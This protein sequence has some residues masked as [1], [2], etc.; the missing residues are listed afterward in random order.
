M[1]RTCEVC[2]WTRLD[3]GALC[4]VFLWEPVKHLLLAGELAQKATERI[5]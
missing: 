5:C 3:A 2:G 1:S 4:T